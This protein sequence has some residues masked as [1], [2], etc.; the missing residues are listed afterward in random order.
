[1]A[2]ISMGRFAQVGVNEKVGFADDKTALQPRPASKGFFGRVAGWVRNEF[3]SHRAEKREVMGAFLQTLRKEYGTT[4]GTRAFQLGVGALYSHSLR[5]TQIQAARQYAEAAAVDRFVYNLNQIHR[6]GPPG[7]AFNRVLNELHI[8]GSQLSQ[9]ERAQL[10]EA[11][12]ARISSKAPPG[13]RLSWEQTLAEARMAVQTSPRFRAEHA[14]GHAIDSAAVY[15]PAADPA[16]VKRTLNN[17]IASPGFQALPRDTREAIL[18]KIADKMAY[19]DVEHRAALRLADPAEM[20]HTFL[21]I[22]AEVMTPGQ[23]KAQLKGMDGPELLGLLDHAFAKAKDAPY[24]E[25]REGAWALTSALKEM[26]AAHTDD[27]PAFDRLPAAEARPLAQL[28]KGLES[29]RFDAANLRE[30]RGSEVDIEGVLYGAEANATERTTAFTAQFRAKTA[31]LTQKLA[32]RVTELEGVGK[33]ADPATGELRALRDKLVEL[34]DNMPDGEAFTAFTKIFGFRF[35]DTAPFDELGT[36]H[37]DPVM[38]LKGASEAFLQVATQLR[39]QGNPDTSTEL[40]ALNRMVMALPT[41]GKPLETLSYL[42]T[43]VDDLAG[44]LERLNARDGGEH[45]L[46]DYP[47]LVFDQSART[48][49]PGE[50]P[51]YDRNTDY[52]NAL[53]V[54]TG[55]NI[56]QVSMQE[57]TALAD[58]LGLKDMFDTTGAG[59]AG[60]GGARNMSF[61]LGPMLHK[62]LHDPES[63][64]RSMADLIAK[65]KAELE[66]LMGEV[67]RGT[68]HEMV[69]MGDD[70]T[71]VR[72]GFMDAKVQLAAQHE[73][74]YAKIVTLTLGRATT[75]IPPVAHESVFKGLRYDDEAMVFGLDQVNDVVSGGMRA[76]QWEGD[77][78]KAVEHQMAGALSHPGSCL[79]LPLPSEEGQFAN[80]KHEVVDWLGSALHHPGDRFTGVEARMSQLA[81]YY[82]QAQIAID[83]L[84]VN[85]KP[86]SNMLPWNDK[87]RSFDN[88]GG[89]YAHAAD[90]ATQRGIQQAFMT[91]LVDMPVNGELLNVDQAFQTMEARD[92]DRL[93]ADPLGA[94]KTAQVKAAFTKASEAYTTAIAYRD[95]LIDALVDKF[96]ALPPTPGKAGIEARLAVDPQDKAARKDALN[97]LLANAGPDLRTRLDEALTAA[98]AATPNFAQSDLAQ[99]FHLVATSSLVRFGALSERLAAIHEG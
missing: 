47:I 28:L 57:V 3:A 21:L 37:L 81:G 92:R 50:R 84:G 58:K 94:E 66:A 71:T 24:G 89:I 61:L 51:M 34:R 52:I 6:G 56:V 60:F 69:L 80:Y 15:M 67:L 26:L 29:G 83:L 30:L 72:P 59:R 36:R 22:A 13:G 8:D 64:V 85:D 17:F 76:T 55:A 82:G 20:R 7:T 10:A 98:R 38:S 79:D 96:R 75:K 68:G 14:F 63:G 70:D 9:E 33:G 35:E 87:T 91:R 77:P 48:A 99:N 62:A 43:L 12:A 40:A 95:A 74:D 2:G 65:P 46:A 32:D 90:P 25:F 42:S 16:A 53:K 11:I 73:D 45:R 49:K 4:V 44:T 1:M 78:W 39:A 93:A 23:I 31:E 27:M 86:H 97:Y 5:G 88:I 18:T 54:K 19:N 41:A